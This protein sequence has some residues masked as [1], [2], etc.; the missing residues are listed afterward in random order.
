MQLLSK[1]YYLNYK[2]LIQGVGGW[3]HSVL[4]LANDAFG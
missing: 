4:K 3:S 1:K 2:Q